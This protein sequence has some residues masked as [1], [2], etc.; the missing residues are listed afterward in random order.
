MIDIINIMS[1][2]DEQDLEP[3]AN[4]VLH[5]P[6]FLTQ[7]DEQSRAHF[8][9]LVNQR[10][11]YALL[12]ESNGVPKGLYA[13]LCYENGYL[14]WDRGVTFPELKVVAPKT[15]IAWKAIRDI[16]SDLCIQVDLPAYDKG[17]LNEQAE[18]LESSNT[19]YLD[20][21]NHKAIAQRLCD[22]LK[23]V[24]SENTSILSDLLSRRR[25]AVARILGKSYLGLNG[26]LD[27]KIV[28]L[29]AEQPN[30]VIEENNGPFLPS[31]TAE[32]LLLSN[33]E[34]PDLVRNYYLKEFNIDTS[35]KQ[36]LNRHRVL[37]VTKKLYREPKG[38]QWYDNLYGTFICTST[39]LPREPDE[40]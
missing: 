12:Q 22:A 34:V 36:K 15:D 27:A 28:N 7:I 35:N 9:G 31:F 21:I 4:R 32:S 30:D 2:F 14:Y 24:N 18:A 17:Q 38:I 25:E 26:Q 20:H 37:K 39:P 23:E 29:L 13:S 19:E 33:K 16:M 3:P 10:I 11:T 1:E 5:A 40:E 6:E 8:L